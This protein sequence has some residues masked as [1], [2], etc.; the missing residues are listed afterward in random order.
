[1]VNATALPPYDAWAVAA[2]EPEPMGSHGSLEAALRHLDATGGAVTSG[3]TFLRW[4]P[5]TSDDAKA[6]LRVALLQH[7]V[8]GPTKRDEV[9]TW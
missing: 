9:S 4:H 7:G 6:T 5:A 3:M 2:G 1:M 8:R